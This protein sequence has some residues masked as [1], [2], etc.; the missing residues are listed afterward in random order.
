M[1]ITLDLSDDLMR[2]L[3]LRANI[4]RRA[5]KDLI[6]EILQQGTS[7]APPA[8]FA[9]L[10]LDS[11]VQ[12]NERGLPIVQCS[13]NAPASRMSATQLLQLEQGVQI[14]EDLKRVGMVS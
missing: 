14:E 3:K 2:E 1:K 11:L 13:P 12:I 6:T 7:M 9:D 10:P 8:Q 4:Q 5:L